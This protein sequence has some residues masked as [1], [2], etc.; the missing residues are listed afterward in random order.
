MVRCITTRQA[1]GRDRC[2]PRDPAQSHVDARCDAKSTG[3]VP[4]KSDRARN[5]PVGSSVGE[6]CAHVA[7]VPMRCLIASMLFFIVFAGSAQTMLYKLEGAQATRRAGWIESWVVACRIGKRRTSRIAC[8]GI[9]G[10]DDGNDGVMHKNADCTDVSY[11]ETSA[12]RVALLLLLA[13]S[14]RRLPTRALSARGLS[15]STGHCDDVCFFVDRLER[16]EEVVGCETFTRY[17]RALR[18]GAVEL[19]VVDG[20]VM[21]IRAVVGGMRKL[22][23]GVEVFGDDGFGWSLS[24]ARVA[25][26]GR[27]RRRCA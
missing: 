3:V 13:L 8:E 14:G 18:L 10:V 17:R 20:M 7:C 22:C 5:S 25:G 23:D 26:V 16:A 12:G 27:R 19:F 4:E 2:R 15:L 24:W 6:A 1:E 21:M 11:L 9:E